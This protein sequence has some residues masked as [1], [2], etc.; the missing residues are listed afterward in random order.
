MRPLT[1]M[2]KQDLYRYAV[3]HALEWV[4]DETNM[5]DVYARNRIRRQLA[6]L[7]HS[8]RQK[9]IALH[10]KQL[11]LRREIEQKLAQLSS[12]KL[13]RYMIIT[14][15]D[16]VAYEVLYESIKRI[17]GVSLLSTQLSGLLIAFKTGRAG[18]IYHP[19]KY[20]Q[21]KLTQRDGI[22]NRVR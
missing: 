20:V 15:P 22:I 16:D 21:V 4:E 6:R 3:E 5:T 1:H 2:T 9:I 10:Q 17:T 12:E 14:M 7:S 8:Q 13:S 19:A 18:T 11:T